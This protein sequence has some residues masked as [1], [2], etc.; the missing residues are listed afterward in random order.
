MIRYDGGGRGIAKINIQNET[1]S[2][3]RDEYYKG[4]N[5]SHLER[6][7]LRKWETAQATLSRSRP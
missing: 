1:D 6:R 7:Q 3:P 2:S 4:E 5:V